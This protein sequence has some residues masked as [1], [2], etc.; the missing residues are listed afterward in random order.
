MVK[1]SAPNIHHNNSG[2]VQ[3]FVPEPNDYSRKSDYT[4][5]ENICYYLHLAK[6]GATTDEIARH[7]KYNI[8]KS[9]SKQL[10]RLTCATFSKLEGYWFHTIQLCENIFEGQFEE[11]V[12][13]Q[14]VPGIISAKDIMDTARRTSLFDPELPFG[15]HAEQRVTDK[16]FTSNSD[17]EG[18]RKVFNWI[19]C[20]IVTSVIGG[21]VETWMVP[22]KKGFDT[23]RWLNFTNYD[24]VLKFIKKKGMKFNLLEEQYYAYEKN[25]SV[26]IREL[27]P[28][29]SVWEKLIPL[30]CDVAQDD[31]RFPWDGPKYDKM[32]YEGLLRGQIYSIFRPDLAP[33]RIKRSEINVFNIKKV[34]EEIGTLKQ[35]IEV[36]T[37]NNAKD[38]I[39]Q[40]PEMKKLLKT[41]TASMK[42]YNHATAEDKQRITQFLKGYQEK[43]LLAVNIAAENTM[44]HKITRDKIDSLE[45]SVRENLDDTVKEVVKKYEDLSSTFQQYLHTQTEAIETIATNSTETKLLLKAQQETNANVIAYIETLIKEVQDWSDLGRQHQYQIIKLMHEELNLSFRKIK[46]I[47]EKHLSVITYQGLNDYYN[48]NKKKLEKQNISYNKS[49]KEIVP[50]TIHKKTIKRSNKV[51]INDTDSIQV[52]RRMSRKLSPNDE[53]K[54][55]YLK[56]GSALQ[57][58]DVNK[59]IDLD[60]EDDIDPRYEK[61][62]KEYLKVN[63]GIKSMEESQSDQ[64]AA[65][66]KKHETLTS[67]KAIEYLP[68]LLPGSIRRALTD[69]KNNSDNNISSQRIKVESIESKNKWRTLYIWGSLDYVTK[70]DNIER[71]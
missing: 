58:E 40:L 48:R 51:K 20:N 35:I 63:Y 42:I 34:V 55:Y 36:L 50:G 69:L 4:S 6:G 18:L 41:I 3:I 56:Y 46:A 65:V 9:L 38:A 22:K 62:L 32:L 13:Q 23:S 24:A 64:V 2:G 45:T 71:A 47:L 52:S 8:P 54:Q 7:L 10:T 60:L 39:E 21:V 17:F 57:Q 1:S 61:M 68:H 59:E 14:I 30:R 28:G 37:L 27:Y 16:I 44:Q 49:V 67:D 12:G 19:H 66:L 11:G 15:V 70:H 33:Y 25:L 26:L 5:Q 29:I 53:S 31:H 43:L